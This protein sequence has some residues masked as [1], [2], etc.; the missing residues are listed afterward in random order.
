MCCKV[1]EGW[2]LF[3][4]LTGLRLV[5]QTAPQDDPDWYTA[6]DEKEED[7]GEGELYQFGQECLDRV[8]LALGGKTLVPLAGELL[9]AAVA[10]D[11][12]QLGG[13]SELCAWLGVRPE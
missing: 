3:L 1:D 9:A 4:F 11:G 12:K 2:K 5:N 7:A 8:A 10:V 6:E 13:F